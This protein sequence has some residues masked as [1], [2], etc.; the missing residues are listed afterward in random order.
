MKIISYIKTILLFLLTFLLG[1]QPTHAKTEVII[2]TCQ[3]VFVQT[4]TTQP[5]TLKKVVQPNVGFLKEKDRFVAKEGISARN[6]HVF[7]EGVVGALANAVGKQLSITPSWLP[8][9]IIIGNLDNPIGVIGVYEKQLPNGVWIRDTK[10]ALSDI[11]FPETYASNFVEASK[12]GYKML[13]T[14]QFYYSNPDQFWTQFNKPW[15]DGL[16]SSKADVIV[17]SDKSNDLLK[18]K[19]TKND[20]T[21]EAVFD[22][23]P[24]TGEKILTGFGK[25]IQYMENLVQQ[26]LYQWDSVKGIY[27][28]IGN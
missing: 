25:E 28:Y 6:K 3:K 12:D 11:D 7:S 15:L 23:N 24:T 16:V 5:S 21:G 13:N 1:A 22:I 10:N 8:N 27:K 20:L 9:R 26:G 14:N 19:W 4:A 2:P 18:Y 17:L